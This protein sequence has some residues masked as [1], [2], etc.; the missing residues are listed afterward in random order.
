MD[1]ET[2]KSIENRIDE[3]GGDGAVIVRKGSENAEELLSNLIRDGYRLIDSREDDE[4]YT[5]HVI[6]KKK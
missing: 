3:F 6:K 4:F 1:G 2:L 5:F